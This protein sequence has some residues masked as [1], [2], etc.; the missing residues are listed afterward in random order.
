MSHSTFGY[1]I[2]PIG[3]VRALYRGEEPVEA[4]VANVR[5]VLEELG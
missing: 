3:H 4:I 5:A 2:D 1:L